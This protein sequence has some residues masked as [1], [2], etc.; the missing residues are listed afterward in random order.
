MTQA[1][2]AGI[3]GK[4]RKVKSVS[5]GLSGVAKSI[6]S[7]YVGV[8]G[9]ARSVL[10][11]STGVPDDLSFPFRPS[12]SVVAGNHVLYYDNYERDGVVYGFNSNYTSISSIPPLSFDYGS[13]RN[14]TLY[15]SFCGKGVFI[16]GDVGKNTYAEV[17]DVY[18]ENLAKSEIYAYNEIESGAEVNINNKIL[19]IEND[20][21]NLFGSV[22]NSNFVVTSNGRKGNKSKRSGV[23]FSKYGFIPVNGKPDLIE[24]FNE[25]GVLQSTQT[26]DRN[27]LLWYCTASNERAFFFPSLARWGYGVSFDKNLVSSNVNLPDNFSCHGS[28][29]YDFDTDIA[30]L[31]GYSNGVGQFC[32]YDKNIVSRLWVMEKNYF[33]SMQYF[34]NNF[35]LSTKIQPCAFFSVEG[36]PLNYKDKWH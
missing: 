31:L 15:S 11:K 24:V 10:S 33:I 25:N 9:V 32:F 28:N 26:T 36:N 19:L 8:D 2:Y 35:I 13:Y 21:G 22:I 14:V 23:S 6:V 12:F 16:G 4:A 20:A 5:F 30:V 34:N 29:A 3:D 18:N 17:I 1:I 27:N 7:A